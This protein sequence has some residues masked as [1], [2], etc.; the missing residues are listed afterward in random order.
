MHNCNGTL[1]TACVFYDNNDDDI[2]VSF[3][4][5]LFFRCVRGFIFHLF[6]CWL[7]L[8]LTSE[9]E[10][11]MKCM[12]LYRPQTIH[13]KMAAQNV[14]ARTMA[15]QKQETKFRFENQPNNQKCIKFN[16]K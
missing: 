3:R 2:L 15:V 16:C 4:F 10:D 1:H 13:E 14:A 11:E 9:W 12:T 6:D 5:V 7:L 8:P